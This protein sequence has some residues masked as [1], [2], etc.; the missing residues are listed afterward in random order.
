MEDTVRELVIAAVVFASC[1]LYGQR[2]AQPPSPTFEVAS[3]KPATSAAN[4][5]PGLRVAMQNAMQ[6]LLPPGSI[7]VRGA[8]VEIRNESLMNLIAASYRVRPDQISGPPW[9]S[10]LEF[11]VDA[12]IP[13][14]APRAQVNEMLQ[15]LLEERFA[16]K[17][18]RESK[19][20]SGYALIVGKGGSKLKD[21]APVPAAGT[22]G[23]AAGPTQA[24]MPNLN[25][26]RKGMENATPGMN[27][28]EYSRLTMARLADVLSRQMHRPVVDLT[29]LQGTYDVVLE[30]AEDRPDEPGVSVFEAVEKLGLKLDPRK[31]PVETLVVDHIE[32]DPTPN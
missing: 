3:I 23:D 32:K 18:H 20:V 29:G 22:G 28:S 24:P 13:V 11:D 21:S 31:L 14:D 9:M 17:L 4:V 7:P 16:L 19:E 26:L 8:Q 5:P 10:D 15:S 12:K 2:S 25:N 6:S 27:R 1:S 30:T